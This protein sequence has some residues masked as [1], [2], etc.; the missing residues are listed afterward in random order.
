[1]TKMINKFSMNYV[2]VKNGMGIV[3]SPHLLRVLLVN[4]IYIFFFNLTWMS[5]PAYVHLN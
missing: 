4:F 3:I 1:M 2:C 5:G